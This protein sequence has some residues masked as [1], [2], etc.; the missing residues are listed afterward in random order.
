[1]GSAVAGCEALDDSGVGTL[2]AAALTL[3]RRGGKQVA[4]AA[5]SHCGTPDAD[6][7]GRGVWTRR[8]SIVMRLFP[9]RRLKHSPGFYAHRGEITF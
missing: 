1:V 9:H 6:R 5:V 7:R 4:D 8:R 3:R 2:A